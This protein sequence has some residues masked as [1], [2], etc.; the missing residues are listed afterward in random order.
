V[1]AAIPLGDVVGEAQH[2]LV[3]AVVPPQGEV[4]LDLLA[5]AADEIDVLDQG[6]LDLSRWRTKASTPPS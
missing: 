1:G 3:V 2:G 5:L 4:D 6:V